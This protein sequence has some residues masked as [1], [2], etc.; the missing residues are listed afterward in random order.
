MNT[1]LFVKDIVT[2]VCL[3]VPGMTPSLQD[4]PPIHDD[5][6]SKRD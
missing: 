1:P 3:A 5:Q 4:A 6:S 2:A